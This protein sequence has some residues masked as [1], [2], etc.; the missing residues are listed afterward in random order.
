[1]AY[2]N[3]DGLDQCG[4]PSETVIEMAGRRIAIRHILYERGKM[5]TAHCFA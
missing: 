1:V 4:L 2:S 5:T 3:V